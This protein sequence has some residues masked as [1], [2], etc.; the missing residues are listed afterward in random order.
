[1]SPSAGGFLAAA[2]AETGAPLRRLRVLLTVAA[3]LGAVAEVCGVMVL[4]GLR[5]GAFALL[6]L[7]ALPAV[8]GAGRLAALGVDGLPFLGVLTLDMTA[9]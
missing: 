3:P 2:L 8:F 6:K 9:N 5:F 1:M 4:E 7:F